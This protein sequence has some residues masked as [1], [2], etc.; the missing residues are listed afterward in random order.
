M[1]IE[2][3]EL[4]A[5]S[6][7]SNQIEEV[8]SNNESVELISVQ[9]Q[10]ISP[11]EH[12]SNEEHDEEQD[13]EQKY[14]QEEDKLAPPSTDKEEIEGI[15]I[16]DS[17]DDEMP[18]KVSPPRKSARLSAKRRDSIADSDISVTSKC[19]SPIPRRRSMRFNSTSSVDT[20]PKRAKEETII[21][22][23]PTINEAEKQTNEVQASKDDNDGQKSEK[24]LVDEMA[25][26]FVGEFI[27]L[28]DWI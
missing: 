10:P 3:I 21:K 14:E 11:V 5:A 2:I 15:I 25:A 22:K 8:R 12:E 16:D 23:L 19:E 17:S 9:T 24:E 13:K 20:P 28:D 26:A 1:D 6:K 7:Q 18:E 4:G 27:D